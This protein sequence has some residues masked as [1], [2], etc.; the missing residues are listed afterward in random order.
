MCG[1]YLSLTKFDTS[2]NILNWMIVA[3]GKIIATV[4]LD[5]LGKRYTI[6]K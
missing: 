6:I 3:I 5:L 4:S 1:K 2:R